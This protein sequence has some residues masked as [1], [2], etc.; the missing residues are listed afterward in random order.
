MSWKMTTSE[1]YDLIKGK[2]DESYLLWE[3]LDGSD[4]LLKQYK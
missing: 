3:L 4:R 1:K 2:H